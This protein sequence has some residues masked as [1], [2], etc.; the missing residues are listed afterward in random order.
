ML[1]Q[2]HT[3]IAVL[4]LSVLCTACYED[5]GVS[6]H[7]PGVYKGKTDDLLAIS[8]TPEL[9]KKLRKRLK[10]VQTDR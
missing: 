7:S 6:M 5:V 1:K 4:A 3:M 10:E 9:E 2:V 8:G